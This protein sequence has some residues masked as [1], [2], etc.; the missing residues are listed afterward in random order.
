MEHGILHKNISEKRGSREGE[1]TFNH[2]YKK[3]IKR[4]FEDY[5][6]IKD[7]FKIKNNYE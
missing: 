1:I 7:L 4:G 3:L 6:T 5:N 2:K